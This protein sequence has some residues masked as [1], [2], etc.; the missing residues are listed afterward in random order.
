MTKAIPHAFFRQTSLSQQRMRGRLAAG[1]LAETS[2]PRPAEANRASDLKDAETLE[3][4]IK[5]AP[6]NPSIMIPQASRW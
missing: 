6:P 2:A 3:L 5:I 1:A 4:G